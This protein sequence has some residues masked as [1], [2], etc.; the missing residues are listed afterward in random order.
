MQIVRPIGYLGF[1]KSKEDALSALR[2]ASSEW[3]KVK[4]A[5][6]TEPAFSYFDSKYA[7]FVDQQIVALNEVSKQASEAV[8]GL[9][10]WGTFV[11][12][13]NESKAIANAVLQQIGSLQSALVAGRAPPRGSIKPPIVTGGEGFALGPG[14]A[15]AITLALVLILSIGAYKGVKAFRIGP[16]SR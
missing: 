13:A 7:S 11:D 4:A 3:A 16:S 2:N 14:A 15:I 5:L 1:G 9:T 8:Q 6:S 12:R 10:F